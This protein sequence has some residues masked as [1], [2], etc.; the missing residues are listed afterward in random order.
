MRTAARM[1]L[2]V[3]DLRDRARTTRSVVAIPANMRFIVVGVLGWCMGAER[4]Q[5]GEDDDVDEVELVVRLRF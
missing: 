5:G 1:P 2:R 3:S 4:R